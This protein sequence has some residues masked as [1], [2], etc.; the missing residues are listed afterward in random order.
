ME[1]ILHCLNWKLEDIQENLEVIKEQGFTMVL[2]SVLQGQ[3][4][5]GSEWWKAYQPLHFDIKDNR[6][7]NEKELRNLC[8]KG[9]EIGVKVMVDVVFDH[10][11]D[12]EF[13]EFNSKVTI[14]KRLQRTKEQV[15]DWDSRWQ[16]TNLSSG[17]LPHLNYDCLE[18]QELAFKYIDKLINI[19]VSAI[20]IDQCKHIALPNEGSTFFRNLLHR[21][22]DKLCIYGEVIFA[23][24]W[25]IDEYSKYII[26]ITEV[27]NCSYNVCTFYESHD[28]YY[29]F[30]GKDNNNDYDT[31]RGYKEAVLRNKRAVLFFARP[32]N[33]TWKSNEI[34]EINNLKF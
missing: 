8:A 31:I 3:K 19:G 33:D 7:G 28:T 29:N 15:S 18:L 27:V 13:N 11:A 17:N 12:G 9:N 32:F 34:K 21:Y 22:S 10:V 6:L 26:P 4:D 30:G 16:V 24:G 25:L 2:T 20:R 5:D 23:P 1:K 14:P